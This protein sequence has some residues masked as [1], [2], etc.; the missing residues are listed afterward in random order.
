MRS[1][2]WP[3]SSTNPDT[4]CGYE[5]VAHKPHGVMLG[6]GLA[7]WDL[8][9]VIDDHGVLYSDAVGV[10]NDVANQALW[11]ERSLSGHGLHVFVQGDG[12]SQVGKRVSYY[13]HSRFIA[14]TGNRYWP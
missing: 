7:C 11:I 1:N 8:D 5:Q 9:N 6:D 10:L 2:G 14:V 4:W 12:P 3:A 13:T